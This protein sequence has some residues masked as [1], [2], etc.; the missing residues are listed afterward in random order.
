[1]EETI[2]LQ[3]LKLHFGDEFR[4]IYNNTK[5]Y[6]K[7][8][9]GRQSWW[10]DSWAL[11][12]SEGPLSR[13]VEDCLSYIIDEG[14]K[15]KGW[16]AYTSYL[17]KFYGTTGESSH[18][19][20]KTP[21]NVS[22]FWTTLGEWSNPSASP[23]SDT[24]GVEEHVSNSEESVTYDLFE[25]DEADFIAVYSTMGAAAAA[26]EFGMTQE[27]ARTRRNTIKRTVKE[28]LYV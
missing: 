19:G 25:E 9:I 21:F 22:P 16:K 28:R 13:M 7:G 20:N 5:S 11:V 12:Q 15:E 10:K 6:V 14:D 23:L 2:M 3:Q 1:M 24:T 26:E 4:E 18:I 17:S 27:Q 8:L